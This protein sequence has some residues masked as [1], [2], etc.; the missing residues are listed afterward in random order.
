MSENVNL[1][2]N[3][4]NQ[5]SLKKKKYLGPSSGISENQSHAGGMSYNGNNQ[6]SRLKAADQEIL[7]TDKAVGNL[8]REHTKLKRRLD[9]VRDPEFLIN[10]KKQLK[11]TEDDIQRQHKLKK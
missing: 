3:K 8:L 9:E 4:M 1:L 2:I 7:N 6:T 11:D 5:E 10:L